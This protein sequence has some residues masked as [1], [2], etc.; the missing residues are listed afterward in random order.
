MLKVVI[1]SNDNIVFTFDGEVILYYNNENNKCII[2]AAKYDARSGRNDGIHYYFHT[3]D[4]ASG[5]L[6]TKR[7]DMTLDSVLFHVKGILHHFGFIKKTIH[8]VL[9]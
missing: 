6:S 7:Q 1:H 3:F 5:T 4:K 8:F 2:I 9:T